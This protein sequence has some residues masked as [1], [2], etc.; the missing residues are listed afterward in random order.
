M[1]TDFEGIYRTLQDIEDAI[2]TDDKFL[3][4]LSDREHMFASRVALIAKRLAQKL[5][6]LS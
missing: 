5:D 2:D 6:E 4:T 3:A 1:N